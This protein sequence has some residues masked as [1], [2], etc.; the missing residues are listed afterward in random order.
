MAL[1]APELGREL[2]AVAAG[3]G[4]RLGQLL[5]NVM[6][7]RCEASG[8]DPI[9]ELFYVPDGRLLDIVKEHVRMGTAK[10]EGEG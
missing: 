3:Q 9:S 4:M 7:S 10:T 8:T 1:R 6:T 5:A 2:G